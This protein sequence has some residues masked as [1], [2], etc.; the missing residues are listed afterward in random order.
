M[1][2]KLGLL[3]ITAARSDD[4][5]T[6]LER[7]AEAYRLRGDIEGHGRT[8]ALIGRAYAIKGTPHAGIARLRPL[9]APLEARG[10][11]HGLAAVASAVASALYTALATLSLISP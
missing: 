3:L 9:L 10:P 2:E 5:L 11:S 8:M 6:L 7:A 4:A 1:R